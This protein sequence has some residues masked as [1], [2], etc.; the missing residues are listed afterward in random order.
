MR[1]LMLTWEYPPNS[2][3]GLGKHAEE[4][5]PALARQGVE[6]HVVTPRLKGGDYFERQDHNI[7]VYR[8]DPP[9]ADL[10]DFFAVAWQTNL[11][12]QELAYKLVDDMAR[13]GKHFDLVHVHEWLV[14]FAGGALKQHY[15][16]PLL[17][18]IHATERGR[19]RGSLPGDLSRA[20][21]NVEWWLT[22]ESWRAICC[23]NYMISEVREYFETPPDKID[24]VPNGV[25]ARRFDAYDGQDL[26]EFRNQYAAPDQKIVFHVGRMVDEKGVRVLV[27]SAPIVMASYPKIKYVIS[28]TGPSL[29]DYRNLA[30]S[31]GLGNNFYFTGFVSDQD[32]DILYKTADVAAFPSL[33]EPFGI[34]ALEAM[35]AQTPVVVA[36]TGGLSE[37]VTN[38]ET[39]L[40]VYPGSPES[41]AWG[42]LHTLNHP[43]WSS[44]RVDN[45]YKLVRE[46]YTWDRVATMTVQVYE[47]VIREY[48]ASDWGHRKPRFNF[49][50]SHI[51]ES[52]PAAQPADVH[53]EV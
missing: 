1:V 6:V 42:I 36:D 44:A 29:N 34:V 3:G 31:M 5:V 33:Y 26:S 53:G 32:R 22:Y 30:N 40:C 16:I 8:V 7:F 11:R 4:I 14:A 12:L 50:A 20:I 19:G 48:L 25:D 41:L 45:A 10:S 43:E 39:G 2:V 47:R 13:K 27:E 51:A 38:H 9:L 28:G 21:N 52:K 49:N 17:A 15:K 46:Q 37:V 23:S 35:A 24:M 18:T